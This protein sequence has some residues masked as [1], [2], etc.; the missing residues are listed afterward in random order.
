[1]AASLH[2]LFAVRHCCFAKGRTGSRPDER[3]TRGVL[4]TATAPFVTFAV[5]RLYNL[6]AEFGSARRWARTLGL[7]FITGILLGVL[8]P[9]GSFLN[10][11]IMLRVFSWT[12]NVVMGTVMVGVLMPILVRVVM[13]LQAPLPAAL[14]VAFLIVNVP[15]SLFSAA[16]GYWLWPKMIDRV[17][18]E[19]WYTQSLLISAVIIGLWVLLRFALDRAAPVPLPQAAPAGN[20]LEP[21]LCLQMEDHYVRV[22]RPSGSTLELMPL[23]EAIERYGQGGGV[24]VHRS[25]WVAASAV[26]TSERDARN[27]RL[28][29]SNGVR[30]PVARNRVTEVRARGWIGD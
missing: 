6:I 9:F 13:R 12:V 2:G 10:G 4:W 29:L 7:A 24:Q 28:H 19:E 15:T 5:M 21:V 23:R 14:V 18:P 30:V 3:R 16:F 26:E 8:G 17:R 1:M 22:H 25:W 11:N 27:W 20:G